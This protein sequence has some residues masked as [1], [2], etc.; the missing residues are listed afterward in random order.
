VDEQ[1]VVADQAMAARMKALEARLE[2][3]E[4]TLRRVLT[5]LVDWAEREHAPWDQSTERRTG[6]ERRFHAV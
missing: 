1:P 3:Q 4:A 2:E 5:L 6:A